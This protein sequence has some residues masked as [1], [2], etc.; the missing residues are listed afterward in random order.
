MI[1][2]QTI[3]I[4]LNTVVLSLISLLHFYWVFGGTWGIEASIPDHF[5]ERFFNPKYQL[6]NRFATLLVAVGL[7]FFIMVILSNRFEINAYLSKEWAILG[8]RIIG[9]L[10]LIRAIG[11]FNVCGIFKKES[12]SLFAK[13]DSR[14][15]IPLCLFL[16]ITAILITFL[17]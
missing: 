17:F 13:W 3:L 11:D 14:L 8:S 4:L 1:M 12:D 6:M 10:F 9:G 5:K 7:I 16:G 2:I 15:F